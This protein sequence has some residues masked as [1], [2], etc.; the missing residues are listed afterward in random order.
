[1]KKKTWLA[2]I[3]T[4]INMTIMMREESKRKAPMYTNIHGW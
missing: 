4:N 2:Y 1:M 3:I